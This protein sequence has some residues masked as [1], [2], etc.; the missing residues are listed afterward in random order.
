MRFAFPRTLAASRTIACDPALAWDILSEYSAWTE[1]LPLVTKST[2]LA[3]E[4]NFALLDLELAPFPGRKIAVECLHAPNSKVLMKSL[5]GQDPEFVLDWTIA[6]EGE[7]QS[8]VA[9]KCTW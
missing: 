2:P 1:W 8:K 3:R 9:V 6:P 4:T 5:I 7:S